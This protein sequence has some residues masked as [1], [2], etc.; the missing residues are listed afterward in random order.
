MKRM[1]IYSS[2]GAILVAVAILFIFCFNARIPESHSWKGY[3][4][5]YVDRTIPESEVLTTF[6]DY[7]VKKIITLSGQRQPFVSDYVPVQSLDSDEYLTDR[8]RYFFDQSQKM[9]L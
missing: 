5:V 7:G 3:F 1:A 9:Q 6:S 8:Q 4:V 2:V